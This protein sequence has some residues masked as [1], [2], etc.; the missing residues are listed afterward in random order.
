MDTVPGTA[1]CTSKSA[2]PGFVHANDTKARITA[3]K[4]FAKNF[5]YLI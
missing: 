3:A 4:I 5:I 1:N 2:V